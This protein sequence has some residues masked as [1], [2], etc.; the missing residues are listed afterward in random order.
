MH[1]YLILQLTLFWKLSHSLLFSRPNEVFSSHS[2]FLALQSSF[3]LLP[4][5]SQSLAFDAD[6]TRLMPGITRF[7]VSEQLMGNRKGA[8]WLNY[9]E[10]LKDPDEPWSCT[11]SF[12][13]LCH[14]ASLKPTVSSQEK[15]LLKMSFNSED[16]ASF[17]KLTL[18]GITGIWS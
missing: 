5:F 12:S 10:V 16:S 18:S 2:R 11:N 7:N 15:L 14:L 8:S 9:F 17:L 13:G 3:S 1:Q 6:Q 4:F